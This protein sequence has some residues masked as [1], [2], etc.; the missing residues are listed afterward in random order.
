MRTTTFI[1]GCGHSGTSLL[2]NMFAAHADV[3]IPLRETGIFLAGS[4][5]EAQEGWRQLQ[6]E[7][8]LTGK[9]HL[10][11]KT[12]KHVRSLAG[13]RRVVPQARFLLMVRDGRDVVASIARSFGNARRGLDRWIDENR[14]VRAES[15]APDVHVLRYED[16]IVSPEAVLANACAFA[17]ISFQES[18]LRYHEEQR[19]GS[20]RRS[21][22]RAPA[23]RAAAIGRCATGRSTSPFSTGAALG[24]SGSAPKSRRYS[25]TPPFAS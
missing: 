1:A 10:V 11:E 19:S 20:G 16:L 5:E 3:Y 24:K 17:G 4:D 9:P 22:G 21:C 14:I 12:P 8:E 7:A 23:W 13:I 6:A 18:I 25:A 15:T 2:A